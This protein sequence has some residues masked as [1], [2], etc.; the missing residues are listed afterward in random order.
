[1]RFLIRPVV[2]KDEEEDDED[3]KCD[4]GQAI[5]GD[6]DDCESFQ[7]CEHSIWSKRKCPSGLQWNSLQHFCDWPVNVQC[8]NAAPPAPEVSVPEPVPAAPA[9]E[10]PEAPAP[11][12]PAPESPEVPAPEAPTAVV[13]LVPLAPSQPGPVVSPPS[14]SSS[15]IHL[16]KDPCN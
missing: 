5:K 16:V 12:A 15:N 13:P 14:S 4:N 8:Q 3:K 11:A 7:I 9:P 1:M 2:V 10:S 6:P